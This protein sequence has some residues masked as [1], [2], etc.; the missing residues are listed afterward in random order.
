MGKKCA[1]LVE[2]VRINLWETLV[3]THSVLKNYTSLG[4]SA[5]Y[6]QAHKVYFHTLKTCYSIWEDHKLYT[7][8]TPPTVTTICLFIKNQLKTG[9]F[10]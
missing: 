6:P 8:S 10:V 2:G 7:P 1:Q 4:I 5:L 9:V 3:Y